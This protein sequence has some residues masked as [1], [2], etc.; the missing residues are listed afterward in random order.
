MRPLGSFKLFNF[1]YKNIL[2]EQK[3]QNAY[4]RTK[5]NKKGSVFMC[6]KTSKGKKV[7]SSLIWVFV[8]FVIFV[9]EKS[10]RKKI[11]M[12]KIALMTSFTLLLLLFFRGK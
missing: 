4:K 10:F 2:S 8:L 7:V 12:F 9:L 3:V 1:F 6:L 5:T 11:K